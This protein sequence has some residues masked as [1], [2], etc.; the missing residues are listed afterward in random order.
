VRNLTTGKTITVA[1]S[2]ASDM[3]PSW[4]ALASTRSDHVSQIYTVTPT[5]G[6]VTRISYSGKP[7]VMPAWSH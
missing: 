1:D 5:G 3:N 6:T 4:I 2:P 7:E